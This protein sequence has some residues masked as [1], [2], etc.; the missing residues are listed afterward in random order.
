MSQRSNIS[1]YGEVLI[2]ALRP[3][4]EIKKI[5]PRRNLPM[6]IG[7][8]RYC[9]LILAGQFGG[10]RQS[11]HRMLTI[12]SYP[13]ILGL[14]GLLTDNTFTYLKALTPGMVGRISLEVVQH[15]IQEQN[16]WE[17]L[18]K[19]MI[20]ISR[21]LL[22][23]GQQLTAPTAFEIV[24]TQLTELMNE[25]ISIRNEI[26]AERYIRDKTELSRSRIMH[27]LSE[28]KKAGHIEIQKGLLEQIHELPVNKKA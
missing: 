23:S 27:I 26:T 28:L 10:Y 1:P 8:A 25:D 18:S 15:T 2:E 21:R 20:Y 4:A 17:I 12:V 6:N 22:I 11:D 7:N 9:Y 14:G 13:A 19:H 5:A 3:Y 24:C 16:L